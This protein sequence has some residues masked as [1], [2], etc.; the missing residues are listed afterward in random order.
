MAVFQNVKISICISGHLGQYR[1]RINKLILT[2]DERHDTIRKGSLRY[3]KNTF[4]CQLSCQP[5]LCYVFQDISVF[6]I[7]AILKIQLT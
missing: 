7:A 4:S 2:Q 3:A 5:P 1:S 6:F